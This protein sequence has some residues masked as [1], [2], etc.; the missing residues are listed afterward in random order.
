MK[1]N[2]AFEK[3]WERE[4]DL[5]A[6]TGETTDDIKEACEVAWENGGYVEKHRD[7]WIAWPET[8]PPI[9]YRRQRVDNIE[10]TRSANVLFTDGSDVYIGELWTVPAIES[11]TAVYATWE[12]AHF[13]LVDGVTHWMP[14]PELPTT[15]GGK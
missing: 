2:E 5:L 15:E 12:A 3:W 11:G 10:V 4:G 13:G 6:T 7:K 9:A 1:K 8:H 14:L